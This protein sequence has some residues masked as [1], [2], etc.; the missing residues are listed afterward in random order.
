MILAMLRINF[1]DDGL[2]DALDPKGLLAS[3]AQTGR[4][5]PTGGGALRA[6]P[7]ANRSVKSGEEVQTA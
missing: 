4:R 1:G 7:R 5:S 3:K 2:R 6:A